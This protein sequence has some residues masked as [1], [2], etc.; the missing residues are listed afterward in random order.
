MIPIILLVLKPFR[1]PV[2]LTII[3][4]AVLLGAWFKRYLIVIPTMLHPHLPI[5]NV[6]DFFST[7]DPTFYEIA[8]TAGAFGITLIIITIL[9]KLF[10]ILPVWE[11]AEHKGL[12]MH[13]TDKVKKEEEQ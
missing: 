1:K 2:P 7:Y 13:H 8:I 9:S 6:P 10:P 12:V 3:S 11:M 4:I 5:Q